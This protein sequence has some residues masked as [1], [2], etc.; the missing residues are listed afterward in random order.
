MF[1]IRVSITFQL[2]FLVFERQSRNNGRNNAVV[3]R[4]K[5][6][7]LFERRDTPPSEAT[8]LALLVV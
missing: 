2:E 8:L 4:Y 1:H 6:P 3:N 5:G 7:K